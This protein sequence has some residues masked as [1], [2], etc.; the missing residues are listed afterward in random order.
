MIKA[1]RANIIA[2]TSPTCK[3]HI[4]F[5]TTPY[6]P[7]NEAF[8]HN[9]YVGERIDL[10][11]NSLFEPRNIQYAYSSSCEEY[12]EEYSY[13]GFSPVYRLAE[14]KVASLPLALCM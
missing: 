8:L 13:K 14:S 10:Q 5:I 12:T 3:Q 9:S 2:K 7:F 11:Y 1:I 6:T 4:F